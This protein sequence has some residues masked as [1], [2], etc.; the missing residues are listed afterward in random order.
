[1]QMIPVRVCYLQGYLEKCDVESLQGG[2]L[3]KERKTTREGILANFQ[4]YF[5]DKSKEIFKGIT[6]NASSHGLGFLTEIDVKE[7]Q[8]IT[9]TKTKLTRMNTTPDFAGQNATVVWVKK[10][11]EYV[12]AG[13]KLIQTV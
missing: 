11:G 5:D 7:G 12:E 3:G 10:R 6:F 13:A 8:I 9:I 4:F 1:M 2:S